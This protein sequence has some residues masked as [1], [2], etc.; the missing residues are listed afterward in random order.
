L[1]SALIAC[2]HPA[3]ASFLRELVGKRAGERFVELKVRAGGERR[4]VAAADL[5]AAIE[6]ALAAS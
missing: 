2:S 4:D 1:A 6:A 3:F 5:A